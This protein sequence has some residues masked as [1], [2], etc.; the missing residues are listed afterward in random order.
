MINDGDQT[1]PA[2]D[3]RQQVTPGPTSP[4]GERPAHPQPPTDARRT[5]V[6]T[7][8]GVLVAVAVLAAPIRSTIVAIRPT[9]S[10]PQTADPVSPQWID[11]HTVRRSW[12][13]DR[14]A[15]R[16][17]PRRQ[18]PTPPSNLPSASFSLTRT[19]STTSTTPRPTPKP[20]LQVGHSVT[21]RP[22]GSET[23]PRHDDTRACWRDELRTGGRR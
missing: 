1:R 2:Q 10:A 7:A 11:A 3:A 17:R 22:C 23:G 4:S 19:T 12:P 5:P 18:A 9:S 15:P 13:G 8:Q 14:R 6:L 21:G 16:S 20:Q